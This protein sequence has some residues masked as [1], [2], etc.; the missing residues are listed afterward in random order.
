MFTGSRALC[1]ISYEL[2]GRVHSYELPLVWTAGRKT[3]KKT[4]ELS[5]CRFYYFKNTYYG[6]AVY[7]ISLEVA[8]GER[9]RLKK[10]ALHC[11]SDNEMSRL[12][13]NGFQSWSTSGERELREKQRKMNPLL[14]YWRKKYKLDYLGDAH[15]ADAYAS[16]KSGL[17]GVVRSCTFAYGVKK[18]GASRSGTGTGSLKS[19]TAEDILFIGSNDESLG[20][21][22]IEM[23]ARGKKLET[24]VF[25]ECE[26]L[27][28]YGGQAES[29]NEVGIHAGENEGGNVRA[30]YGSYTL[31]SLF[32]GE[33]KKDNVFSFWAKR[34]RHSSPAGKRA[35]KPAEPAAGWTSWYRYYEKIDEACILKNL[36]SFSDAE[37]PLDY[38]QIDDGW[39]NAV[40]DW[41]EVKDSFPRGMKPIADAV[42]AAGYTPGL[43]LAPFAAEASSRLFREHP[44]WFVHDAEG[45]PVPA[46]N[47]PFNWSGY[48]YALKCE[49]P[50]VRSYLE[51]VFSVVYREWGFR[52]VKL[53]FLYAA[54][55]KPRN[56]RS[57]GMIMQQAMD[58]L[59]SIIDPYEDLKVLACGVPLASAFFF[60]DYCRIG[61]DVS[62]KWEDR[63]LAFMRFPE[64]VSTI[65]SLKST[66]GRNMLNYRF[67]VNDPDVFFLRKEGVQMTE[68]QKHSLFLANNIFGGLIFTSDDIGEY[69]FPEKSLYCSHFPV[70]QKKILSVSSDE[71]FI[72]VTFQIERLNYIAFINLT[73]RGRSAK[74]PEGS[75]T[76]WHSRTD[77]FM[78]GS[79]HLELSR[80]ESRCFLKSAKQAWGVMGS[81]NR[82]FPGSEVKVSERNG[83]FLQVELHERTMRPGTIYIRTPKHIDNVLVNKRMMQVEDCAGVPCV[84]LSGR[85]TKL[86]DFVED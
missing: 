61:S 77:G 65:N 32:C 23:A 78:R 54:G 71:G 30:G 72:S 18:P 48:F 84:K 40:G 50:E 47:N 33:E 64:R 14:M 60:A 62:P 2:N 35:K 28:L 13:S 34:V 36:H 68:S 67:F 31:F 3:E 41:L 46:G 85:D 24:T 80:Y 5:G 79:E 1:A 38:F 81:T 37:V 21:T 56:G 82:L 53:D 6:Y 45:K 22:I 58:L 15:F 8:P 12:F 51:K 4:E 55:I 69:A 49:I 25:K 75:D 59:R 44:D 73:S 63:R 52:L 26:G 74:L 27:E 19:G 76:L 29:G 66:V 10:L 43:W 16:E 39:Q 86:W 42:N 57:R 20:Y 83:E 11:V 70:R 17:P 9:I 7:S